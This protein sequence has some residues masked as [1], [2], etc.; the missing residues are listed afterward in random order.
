[1]WDGQQRGN[2][3]GLLPCPPHS[4]SDTTGVR[5]EIQQETLHSGLLTDVRMA[6]GPL[7]LGCFL[8]LCLLSQ[9]ALS[10]CMTSSASQCQNAGF[11]PGARLAGLG[12]D[13]VTLQNKAA[14]VIDVN[15]W[16]SA[17][18]TCTLCQNGHLGNANQRLPISL[19]DWHTLSSCPPSLSSQ[20]YRSAAELAKSATT[21]VSNDWRGDLDL[22]TQSG[23]SD[24]VLAGSKSR[25]VE[26]STSHSRRDHHSFTS[27]QFQCTYYQYRVKD[28][29]LLAPEF[30]RSLSSLPTVMNDRNKHLYRRLVATYGTHFLKS[31]QLGGRY[32]DVTAIQT[33]KAVSQGYSIEEVKDCLSLEAKETR[34]LQAQVSVSASQCQKLARSMGHYN[35]V[36]QAF[37]DRDTEVTG[38]RAHQGVD[39]FSGDSLAFSRW[40]GSLL[41]R[42]GLV[43][44]AL[45][46]LHHLLPA[47]NPKQKNL[48]RY[49]SDY[50]RG[51]ALNQKCGA[52]HRC[53][54]GSYPNPRQ[55]CSCLCREDNYV[56]RNCCPK[57]KGFG[58]LVVTVREG[59]DLWGD[60]SSGTD[61][62]VVFKY[63]HTQDRTSIVS[64]NNNPT[65]NA[66]LDL[67]QVKAGTGH[68]LIIE[69]WDQD[70][71]R[72]DFLGKCNV[73]LTSGTHNK[74]CNLKHG[75][76]T[77]SYTFTCGPYLGGPTCQAY[78]PN[79]GSTLFTPYLGTSNDTLHL[80]T[81]LSK[82]T[83]PAFP[84]IYFP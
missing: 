8:L 14:F 39:L 29:P 11:V 83:E 31:V 30:A 15:A 64:N 4:L 16:R 68:D 38:G 52:G 70:V 59:R 60:G 72:D 17:N 24:V 3:S 18:G 63:G 34:G 53:P 32:K 13:V 41:T 49:I 21:A 81:I 1:M 28:Q 61:G 66:H 78:M 2:L 84:G 79:P 9:E 77:Y 43:R 71:K 62:Y 48:R 5:V 50:I 82:P 40:T 36:Y 6:T 7:K 54:H 33:C 56:D 20:L 23:S 80:D 12:Y 25:L 69:A 27:H 26:F 67:G 55:R 76:V 58:R 74:I 37:S 73:R 19:V 10:A 42:P 35:K 65:W 47:G 75:K 22:R 46:P 51:N 57:G 44:Y 45:A